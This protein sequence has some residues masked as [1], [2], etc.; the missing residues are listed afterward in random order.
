MSSKNPFRVI[1]GCTGSVATIKIP[2]LVKSLESIA[3]ESEHSVE[4][5]VVATKPALNFFNSEE[6]SV[7]LLTDE[8][9][10]EMWTKISDPILHIELRNWAD[11]LLI[12]PLDANTLAKIANGICDNLLT[13]ILRAWDMN[14]PVLF[15][16]AMNTHM[17]NHPITN[18]HVSVLEEF[19]FIQLPC[20]AKRLACGDEGMGAMAEV[21]TIKKEVTNL[22]SNA[23][24]F[25]V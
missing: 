25:S 6:I 15:C 11:L 22:I 5:R 9:E 2:Q 3:T 18:K 12:A 10:W 20:V 21:D 19:G 1:V 14:K 4:V 17:W 8:M 24:Q 16:P 23:R 13:L 7:P